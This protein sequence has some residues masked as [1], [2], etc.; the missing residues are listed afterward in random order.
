M[1]KSVCT[2]HVETKNCPKANR[3]RR[4][5]RPTSVPRA[6][7]NASGSNVACPLHDRGKHGKASLLPA[8]AG[9]LAVH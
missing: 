9:S 1:K 3:A 8:G 4:R 2:K 7:C 6:L 5:Q